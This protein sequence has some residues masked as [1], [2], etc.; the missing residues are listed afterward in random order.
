MGG[1]GDHAVGNT[2]VHHHRSEVRDVG[3]HL[4]CPLD[5][6]ALVRPQRGVLLCEALGVLGLRGRE[7]L[8]AADVHAEFAAASTH[9]GFVAEDRQVG[10]L[11]LQQ[12]AGRAQ[13]RSSSTSG[14]TMCLRS[15]RARS[16]SLYS[17]ICGVTTDGI[18]SAVGPSG[19]RRRRAVPSSSAQCRPFA[20]N[21][22]PASAGWAAAPCG[23]ES[24]EGV[25]RIEDAV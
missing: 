9:T 12:P 14:R 2:Q 20:A 23:V 3:D 19:R 21:R 25:V 22:L 17:N 6:H 7:D 5:S 13:D 10:N 15:R 18:G 1:T 8:R 24:A 16:M 4:A 11:A